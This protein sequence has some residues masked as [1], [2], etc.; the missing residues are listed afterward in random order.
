MSFQEY[1]PAKSI[2][3]VQGSC[4]QRISGK[5]VLLREA[6]DVE[7]VLGGRP[8][9]AGRQGPARLAAQRHGALL[10]GGDPRD[11]LT[12]RRDELR[13]GGTCVL[14]LLSGFA[15][16]ASLQRKRFTLSS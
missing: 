12:G 16:P 10:R 9:E 11:G 13:N 4:L 3:F 15:F 14:V 6:G 2:Y 1:L 8:E 7:V 5:A